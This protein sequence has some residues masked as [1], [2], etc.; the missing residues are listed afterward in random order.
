MGA[1]TVNIIVLTKL[2]SPNVSRAAIGRKHNKSCERTS[3]VKCEFQD[4]PYG[5]IIIYFV[6]CTQVDEIEAIGS[7]SI[8]TILNF[9][10]FFFY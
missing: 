9:Y 3:H 5:F 8:Q 2:C 7:S 10:H 1:V 4:T 6:F